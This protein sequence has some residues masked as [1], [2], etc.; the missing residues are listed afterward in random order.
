ML[1]FVVLVGRVIGDWGGF[2]KELVS[3]GVDLFLLNGRWMG[4]TVVF[5]VICLEMYVPYQVLLIQ[6]ISYNKQI[7]RDILLRISCF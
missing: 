6:M 2:T 7:S 3:A 4:N 5:G 1:I